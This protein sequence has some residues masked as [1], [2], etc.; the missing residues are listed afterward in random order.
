[1]GKLEIFSKISSSTSP[2]QHEKIAE[3]DSRGDFRRT[4]KRTTRQRGEGTKEHGKLVVVTRN[5]DACTYVRMHVVRVSV[6]S[7]EKSM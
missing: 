7:E 2:T 3:T 5:G 6:K 4:G 1:M